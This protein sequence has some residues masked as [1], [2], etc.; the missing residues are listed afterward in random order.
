MPCHTSS[1]TRLFLKRILVLRTYILRTWNA[2]RRVDKT[3]VV[4]PGSEYFPPGKPSLTRDSFADLSLLSALYRVWFSRVSSVGQSPA[5]RVRKRTRAKQK[6]N[7]AV[8]GVSKPHVFD[9][10]IFALALPTLGAVLIDPCLSL[11]DTGYVGRL[12]ALSLAAI[13]PCAAAF[14]FVFVTAR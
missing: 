2:D 6:L 7:S 12:G 4:S 11:V 8:V 1:T 9:K 13:G 5:T 14:N 3:W 10:E